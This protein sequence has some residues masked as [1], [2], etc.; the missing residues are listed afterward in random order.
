MK[1]WQQLSFVNR[2]AKLPE[3]FY[4]RQGVIPLAD[5]QVSAW[6]PQAAQL[7]QLPAAA[8]ADTLSLLLGETPWEGPEPLA[9]VYAGHQFGGYTPRLGDGRG[10]LLGEVQNDQ[11]QVWD[12]HLKGA[13]P[14]PFSRQGDGRA[15]LRSCIRE[16]LASEYMASL[17][18]PT[19]RALCILSSQQR[20]YRERPEP[21][22]MLLRLAKTHIRFGHFEYFYY[23]KEHDALAQLANFV[24]EQLYPECLQ[25]PDPLQ[26][27]FSTV[28][29]RTAVM[30]AG[31]QAYGFC[32]GVMNTDNF[33]MA[34]ETFDYGPYAFMDDFVPDYVC[35]HSDTSGR[36]A[37]HR[38][39][40]VAL[41]NLHALA[42][43]WR[44]LL[45]LEGL[46]AALAEFEPK[47]VAAY[48]DRMRQ[49]LG[50]Q[51]DIEE[52]VELVQDWLQLL[53][54]NGT[55]FTLAFRH[56]ALMEGAT[57]P[58]ALRDLFVDQQALSRWCSRY[59]QRIQLEKAADNLRQQQ[60][61]AVNP[62]FQLRN[63]MAQQAIEAAEQG[64]MSVLTKLQ[65]QLC[66]PFMALE[67][68]D[69]QT[70]SWAKASPDWGK[71]IALSCSS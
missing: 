18:I 33:S 17:A 44:P 64:D 7:L 67:G 28:V 12:L 16:Y 71:G 8:P 9:M 32:H 65:Q 70:I 61:L 26:A 20:V 36:Y 27:V 11:G 25:Q 42:E 69:Q 41:W 39:P 66:H 3:R 6:S 31:W 10:L 57:P 22:A 29:E 4:H 63:Y 13:G 68:A 21:G 35:N 43:S 51:L 37:F 46:R 23:S 52:D 30:V 54:A 49:R 24:L 55:D 50:L 1:S 40:G 19:T 48:A 14:T 2:F 47:L 38:Q 56:L 15:V 53:A 45:P 5:M 60:M 59:W 62:L 58:A 34:G